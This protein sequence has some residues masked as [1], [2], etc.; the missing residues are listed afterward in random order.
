MFALCTRFRDSLW[1]SQTCT[2][3][4]GG[5][6]MWDCVCVQMA[7]VSVQWM[8][9]SICTVKPLGYFTRWRSNVSEL[10]G[11]VETDPGGGW[12]GE[13]CDMC[14]I[15]RKRTPY[16]HTK[17]QTGLI[18]LK[19]RTCVPSVS[20]KLPQRLKPPAA[21]WCPPPVG[22][23][24]CWQQRLLLPH[25]GGNVSAGSTGSNMRMKRQHKQDSNTG[26]S[27]TLTK[28]RSSRGYQ[29]VT[30]TS[31]W[32]NQ[33]NTGYI[34]QDNNNPCQKLQRIY[35]AASAPNCFLPLSIILDNSVCQSLNNPVTLPSNP[36]TMPT[37]LQL[38]Q[39]ALQSTALGRV[40]LFH[41]VRVFRRILKR[42]K[43]KQHSQHSCITQQAWAASVCRMNWIAA[44]WPHKCK[45]LD[46]MC[47]V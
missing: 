37:N 30:K 10:T 29:E 47:C 44:C 36:N 7:Q 32:H 21:D 22:T 8:R 4:L 2:F 26:L 19:E 9:K 16:N 23:A 33:W 39:G 46:H 45:T 6:M 40:L 11:Q 1:K 12:G 41:D 18:F 34:I 38:P 25:S 17:L 31:L 3:L 5:Q 24:A 42:N 27:T 15:N 35:A 14:R 28:E 20:L 13:N 43:T